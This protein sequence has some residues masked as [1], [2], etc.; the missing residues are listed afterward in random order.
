MQPN[1]QCYSTSHAA[2]SGW[3]TS[4]YN[5]DFEVRQYA[6]RNGALWGS[7]SGNEEVFVCPAHRRRMKKQNPIW[8]YVMN[9][10]FGYDESQGSRPRL[11]G[12]G[13]QYGH[14]DRNPDRVLLFAELQFLPNDAVTVNTDAGPGIVNDCTLQ[15]SQ[16][17]ILGFNHP[18]G[19]RGLFAHVAFADGHAEKLA[20]PA[21][22]SNAGWALNISVSNLKDL[23]KWL[24]EGEDVSF[25][26][27]ERK[28]ERF[29][30]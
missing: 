8:S 20:I 4:A 2:Q 16:N 24:C 21:V 6:L 18:N 15:Y 22:P 9:Q 14:L 1:G 11:R 28:Y 26:E 3:F 17:E 7:L 19:K 5:Q 30:D 25:N 29:N 27:K 13:I 12:Y 10:K 23:T